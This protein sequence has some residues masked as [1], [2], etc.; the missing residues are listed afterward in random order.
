M[1]KT[2]FVF[3]GFLAFWLVSCFPLEKP[4]NRQEVNTPAEDLLYKL[5][6]LDISDDRNIYTIFT[7]TGTYKKDVT[8][9]K[10][11][12]DTSFTNPMT[13]YHGWGGNPETEIGLCFKNEKAW[14][15]YKEDALRRSHRKE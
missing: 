6:D 1:K 3:I 11:V 15:K 2:L 9:I 5:L 4:V 14:R 12:Y 13:R 10:L 7:E 8:H